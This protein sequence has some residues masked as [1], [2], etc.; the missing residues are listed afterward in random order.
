MSLLKLNTH[1][2][3]LSL[4]NSLINPLKPSEFNQKLQDQLEK[5]AKDRIAEQKRIKT[6]KR[7][8]EI[9]ST[10]NQSYQAAVDGLIEPSRYVQT[11]HEL[12]K[13]VRLDKMLAVKRVDAKET[14]IFD[15]LVTERIDGKTQYV[16][17][18]SIYQIYYLFYLS[19]LFCK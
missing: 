14:E 5:C 1:L 12:Q 18:V 9:A 4:R 16:L 15:K 6:W 13:T 2:T 3:H 7:S 10:A 11:I 19:E 17:K 8:T